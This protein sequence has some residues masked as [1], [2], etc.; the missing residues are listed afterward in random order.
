MQA[1]L[2]S[3]GLAEANTGVEHNLVVGDAGAP[4]DFERTREEIRNVGDNVDRGIGS[5]AIVHDDNGCAVLGDDPRHVAVALQAPDVVDDGRA[6]LEG[7]GCN[8]GF[9]R[10]DGNWN[11]DGGGGRQDRLKPLALLVEGDRPHSAIGP[12][13]LPADIDDVGAFGGET[14]GVLD[15]LRRVDELAAVGKGVRRHIENAH[16]QR[17]LLLKKIGQHVGGLRRIGCGRRVKLAA[18]GGFLSHR[19]NCPKY[20]TRSRGRGFARTA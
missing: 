20:Q 1:M 18:C 8:A 9:H 6:G 17:T 2:C 12:G 7:P 3:G 14:A 10:V 16:H 15:G 19:L 13:R 5:L 4:G 11:A